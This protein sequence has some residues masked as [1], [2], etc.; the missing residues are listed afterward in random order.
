MTFSRRD[1]IPCLHYEDQFDK[2]ALS[3]GTLI[4]K[5]SLI[6]QRCD[7]SGKVRSSTST[8]LGQASLAERT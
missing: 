1:V 3:A 8:M 6:D 7:K 5:E 4:T 2:L